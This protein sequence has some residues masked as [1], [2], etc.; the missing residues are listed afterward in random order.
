VDEIGIYYTWL[1]DVNVISTA[2]VRYA[3]FRNI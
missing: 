3:L 1:E 2:I